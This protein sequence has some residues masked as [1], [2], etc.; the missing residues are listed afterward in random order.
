MRATMTSSLLT[1]NQKIVLHCKKL[2]VR[3]SSSRRPKRHFRHLKLSKASSSSS[4]SSGKKPNKV[5]A[6]FFLT[7]QK[8][9][10]KKEKM[11][12]LNE[13]ES[14]SGSATDK[15]KAESRKKGAFPSS[16]KTSCLRQGKAHS[17]KVSQDHDAPRDSTSAIL[18]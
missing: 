17:Q 15:K 8:K 4:L 9:K 13:L 11:K 7:I 2:L 10:Q 18:P 5:V 1:F 16:L 3:L 14:F 12:R 6:S